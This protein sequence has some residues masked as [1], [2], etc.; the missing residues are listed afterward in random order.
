MTTVAVLGAGAGGS[1]ATA[2]LVSRGHRVR[3]W[4]RS[5]ATLEAFAAGGGVRYDGVLGE[6]VAAPEAITSDAAEV[7]VGAEAVLVCLPALGHASVAAALADAR[8]SLPIVLDPG[9][10]GGALHVRAVFRAR[11]LEPPPLAEFSTLTYVA[12]KYAPDGVTISGTAARVHAACLPGGDDALAAARELFPATRAEQD[13]LATSLANVNLVLHPPG[14]VLGAAWVE[15]RGGDFR[16]YVEGMTGGVVRLIDALDRERLAVGH[17]FGHELDPLALEMAA[18]GTADAEAAARGD[19][20]GAIRGGAAN[21]TLRA[22]DS[23]QHRYYAEDFGYALLPFC[24]LADIAG[25]DVPVARALLQL[26]SVFVGEKIV[27]G[28]LTAKR[29]GLAGL[30]HGGLLRLVR[31]A[32]TG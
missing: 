25:V 26:A 13:V 9:H 16:F 12:R 15:A 22:P 23:L 10:T 20:A 24:E 6:G 11:G 7:L 3:L 29:L 2:E 18:I 32:P 4:N 5:P 8:A 17:A 31:E 1:A 21:A 19:L 14:A 30:D 27:T 28:G